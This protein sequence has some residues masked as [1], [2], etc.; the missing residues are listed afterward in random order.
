MLKA[1]NE[2]IAEGRRVLRFKSKVLAVLE[3]ST[4]KE[5]WQVLLVVV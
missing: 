1:G 2:Q 5:N 3:M 4:D